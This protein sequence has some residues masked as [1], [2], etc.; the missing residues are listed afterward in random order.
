MMYFSILAPPSDLGAVHFRS[1]L[2]WSKSVISG[3]P[4]AA[5]FSVKFPNY[6]VIHNHQ[7]K[8]LMFTSRPSRLAE[9]K[10]RSVLE[11]TGMKLIDIIFF[12]GSKLH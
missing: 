4:G 7:Y 6:G 3:V 5:D 1:T 12:K 11:W 2:S 9:N 10:T 8:F